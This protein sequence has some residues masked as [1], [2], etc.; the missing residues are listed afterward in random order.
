MLLGLGLGNLKL[1]KVSATALKDAA[2][3]R[4]ASKLGL[5]KLAATALK[6]AAM[7]LKHAAREASS[8]S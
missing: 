4:E 8:Y 6:F 5:G 3:A 2:R 1:G 7:A